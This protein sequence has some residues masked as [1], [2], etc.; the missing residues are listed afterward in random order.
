MKISLAV[1]TLLISCVSVFGQAFWD[2]NKLHLQCSQNKLIAMTYVIGVVDEITNRPYILSSEDKIV[3]Q[4]R[5]LCLPQG[6]T[7]G[8]LA[9]VACKYLTETPENRHYTA[10]INISAALTKAFPCQ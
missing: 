1:F 6:V 7:A 4:R 3:Q 5:Y 10:N 9:D 8:Q 2:G